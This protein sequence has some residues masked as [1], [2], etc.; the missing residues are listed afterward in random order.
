MILKAL[1]IGGAF[2]AWPSL[3][4]SAGIISLAGTVAELDIALQIHLG[5]IGESER[6]EGV[7]VGGGKTGRRLVLPPLSEYF[8]LYGAPSLV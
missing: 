5:A 1:G 6:L 8:L 3:Q 4:A 7:V 2:G